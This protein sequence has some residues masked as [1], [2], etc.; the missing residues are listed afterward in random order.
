MT[1]KPVAILAM[2]CALCLSL[3][4][5]THELPSSQASPEITLPPALQGYV[6]PI[7]DAALEYTADATLYLP[8]H[9]E[10]RL[11]AF[12]GSVSFSAARPPAESLVRALMNHSGTDTTASLGGNTQLSLYGANPV[13]ISGNVAAVNLGASALQM[14]RSKLYI[15]FQAIANTLTELSGIDYVN[16]LVV[17]RAVGL[18]TANTL[19][20][21]AFSRSLGEDINAA[22][23]QKLTRRVAITENAASKALSTNAALYF[24][25]AD[26][27]GML[28]E[29][30]TCSFSNQLVPDMA[31][32]LLRELGKG[33]LQNDINSPALPLLSDMLDEAPEI[34]HSDVL[35]GDVLNLR[36]SFH[37]EDMLE[38]HG[39][40]RANVIAS[41]CYTMTTFFPGLAGVSISIGGASVDTLMLTDSFTSSVLFT[42]HIQQRS[43]FSP[44]LYDLCTLFFADG[45][46]RKLIP[47]KRA[48]PY[49]QKQNPRVLLQELAKGPLKSDLIPGLNAVM[50]VNAIRDP[51]ILGLALSQQTILVNFAPAFLTLGQDMTEQQERLLAYSMVN[52]L[53]ENQRFQC[54]RFFVAGT[55]PEGFSGRIYWSGDF[56]PLY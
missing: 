47:A 20:M 34:S 49:Y 12:T 44:L 11:A 38:A 41:L 22:Y 53:C 19:P 10:D 5:C 14:S 46:G 13:E 27:P 45:E 54:V 36:F 29:V 16:F 32:T 28:S 25:L 39:L 2:V 56:Y 18:D 7:G 43:D 1:K 15:A 37:F 52:T 17:D 8:R 42:D 9:S 40:T 51:D 33:P 31:V 21:G 23:E 24:P 6:A 26:A 55:P 35:G 50:P 48:I 30:R 4:S 3:C